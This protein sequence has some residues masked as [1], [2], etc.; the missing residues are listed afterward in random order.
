MKQV[1]ASFSYIFHPLWMPLLGVCSFFWV[2]PRYINMP[3]LYAKLFATVIMTIVIPILSYYMF[4]NLRLVQ[5]QNLSRVEERRFPLLL[6]ITFIILILRIVFKGYEFPEIHY[7]FVG[8]LGALL[9]ALFLAI[10]KFKTSLHVVGISGLFMFI[11][12]LSIHYNKNLIVLLAALILAVG[13]TATSR[14]ELKAHT[15]PEIIVGFFV[16]TL[17]QLLTFTYW[18]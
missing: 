15:Y 3:L 4:K 6:Q 18:L 2:S 11:V 5:S 12:G 1:I 7:F 8:I 13:A 16:G 17:P 14:L 10:A 9:A